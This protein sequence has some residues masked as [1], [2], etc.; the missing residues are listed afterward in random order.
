[1]QASIHVSYM[2]GRIVYIIMQISWGVTALQF[3]KFLHVSMMRVFYSLMY[4]IHK[5]SALFHRERSVVP[6]GRPVSKCCIGKTS[7]LIVRIIGNSHIR[8]VRTM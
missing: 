4:V 5:D 7:T 1:M 6:S 8:C 2:C 3:K